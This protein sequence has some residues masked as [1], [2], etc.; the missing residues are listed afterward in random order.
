MTRC[1]KLIY[2]TIYFF[3]FFSILLRVI[4]FHDFD[5]YTT[6]LIHKFSS[7]QKDQF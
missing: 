6:E 5:D 3:F 7:T 2:Y 4:V 1:L